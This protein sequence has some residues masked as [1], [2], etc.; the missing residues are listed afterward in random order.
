MLVAPSQLDVLS[1]FLDEFLVNLIS[2][3]PDHLV[4]PWFLDDALHELAP[5]LAAEAPLN[6]LVA[7]VITMLVIAVLALQLI[8]ES[9]DDP[10]VLLHRGLLFPREAGNLRVCQRCHGHKVEGRVDHVQL[11][12]LLA[13]L[14]RLQVFPLHL[15]A[16][17]V[18]SLP[19]ERDGS[20][21]PAPAS[22]LSSPA[23]A[24]SLHRVL[25]P[26]SQAARIVVV[27]VLHRLLEVGPALKHG[28]GRIWRSTT[29]QPP[30]A[31]HILVAEGNGRL[32]HIPP[33]GR[34]GAHVHVHRLRLW[35]F[36]TLCRANV[37]VNAPFHPSPEIQTFSVQLRLQ[38]AQL[39]DAVL[40]LSAEI[41]HSFVHQRVIRLN[42]TWLCAAHPPVCRLLRHLAARAVRSGPFGFS[43]GRRGSLSARSGGCGRRRGGRAK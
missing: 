20:E 34:V 15:V 12:V 14:V 9:L 17:N 25:K 43:P 22:R 31:S 27:R 35:V 42:V 2:V 11:R 30:H 40:N 39:V 33:M 19:S 7:T 6:E 16:P 5:F 41:N 18:P 1:H 32:L 21:C 26:P 23:A 24:F 29:R 37:V 38:L 36:P 28:A 13:F 4:D 8:D 3:S 10:Y